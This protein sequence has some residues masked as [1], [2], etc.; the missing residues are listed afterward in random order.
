[1]A[2]LAS[3]PEI[4]LFG[5]HFLHHIPKNSDPTK[6]YGKKMWIYL[7]CRWKTIWRLYIVDNC[8]S[9]LWTTFSFHNFWQDVKH[10]WKFKRHEGSIAA[11]TSV[12][13]QLWLCLTH[14]MQPYINF[15]LHL[16]LQ[17]SILHPVRPCTKLGGLKVK[18]CQVLP[19]LSLPFSVSSV[20]TLTLKV[21]IEKVRLSQCRIF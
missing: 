1:M 6:N 14:K 12:S 17:K 19:L 7:G 11:S 16:I 5:T 13:R 20:L 18:S 3:C 10:F 9:L 15:Q 21:N 4:V 2:S 8:G